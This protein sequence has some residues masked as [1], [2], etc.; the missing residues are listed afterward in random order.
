M[1]AQDTTAVPVDTTQLPVMS[2]M[3]YA[4]VVTAA[5]RNYDYDIH[6]QAHSY[7]ATGYTIMIGGSLCTVLAFTLAGY[8]L[9]AAF[10]VPDWAEI[11]IPLSGLAVGVGVAFPV[12]FA[13]DRILR[14]GQMLEQTAYLQIS[15]KVSVS[16]SR[17][18][19]LND[20]MDKGGSVGLAV[21][22]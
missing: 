6:K 22:L 12:F 14:K 1:Y 20:R 8:G 19:N 4:G 9:S 21:K 15:D 5:D 16:A 3:H 17:Y 7:K 10:D 2:Q 11:V 18:A 13:G